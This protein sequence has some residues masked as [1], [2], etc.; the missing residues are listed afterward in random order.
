[1]RE[2]TL[3]SKGQFTL[4]IYIRRHFGLDQGD[5]LLC[6]MEHDCIILKPAKGTSGEVKKVLAAI[7]VD[8]TEP[9]PVAEAEE[10]AHTIVDEV[11]KDDVTL[12]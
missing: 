2:V 12:L 11:D 3:T 10:P 8:D 5:T 1:M 6:T 7:H 4:P 9:E